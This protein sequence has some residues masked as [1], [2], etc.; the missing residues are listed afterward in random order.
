MKTKLVLY[1]LLISGVVHANVPVPDGKWTFDDPSDFAKATIGKPLQFKNPVAEVAGPTAEDKAVK[2][3]LGNWIKITQDLVPTSGGSYQNDFSIVMDIRIP[4]LEAGKWRSFFNTNSNNSNGGD[5]FIDP[6]EGSIGYAGAFDGGLY[7]SFG[8]QVDEWYRVAITFGWKNFINTFG[9]ESRVAEMKVYVDGVLVYDPSTQDITGKGVDGTYSLDTEFLLFAD[10]YSEDHDIDCA[11]V[12]YFQRVISSEEVESLGGVPGIEAHS[13]SDKY[14]AWIGEM[15]FLQTPTPTS[16]NV[17]WRSENRESSVFVEYSTTEDMTNVVSAEAVSEVIHQGNINIQDAIGGTGNAVVVYWNTAK[18]EGLSPN[19]EYFYRVRSGNRVSDTYKFKTL[20]D[21]SSKETFRFMMISDTQQQGL[22][23]D[24]I[25]EKA[26]AKIEELYGSLHQSMDFVWHSGDIIQDGHTHS[27]YHPIFFVPFRHFSSSVPVIPIFGNH[28]Y[29]SFMMYQ[30]IKNEDFSI[31]EDSSP[32]YEKAWSFRIQNTVFISLN[33]NVEWIDNHV[34]MQNEQ[35]E[36]LETNLPKFEADETVDF[37]FVST[38][39]TPMSEMWQQGVEPFVRDRILPTI[40]KYPKVQQLS[41]GHTHSYERGIY[42][43][44]SAEGNDLTLVCVAGGGGHRD[45]PGGAGLEQKDLEEIKISLGDY[46]FV[47]G[48]ID[49]TSKTYKFETYSLGSNE[50][51]LVPV[52]LVDSWIGS[53]NSVRPAIPQANVAKEESGK[54][55]FQAKNLESEIGYFTTHFQIKEKS[56][57]NYDNPLKDIQQ[58]KMN[59]YGW[60]SN[61][62]PT[63]KNAG[64]DITKL[65]LDDLT[66]GKEYDWRIR[67]RDNYR[68]W[69]D[70]S[71]GNITSLESIFSKSLLLITTDTELIIESDC[72]S[73]GQISLDVFDIKGQKIYTK[74]QQA[75]GS[76][77]LVMNHS[78]IPTGI[79]LVKI[80]MNGEEIV[81]KVQLK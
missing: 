25:L 42:P 77:I 62:D 72:L 35:I 12:E 8:F 66:P 80:T 65:E 45:V 7:S 51:P 69:S 19:T 54:F 31:F 38:H 21:Q 2:V 53:A 41:Y 9:G 55:I 14:K 74:K 49:P 29:N 56:I 47:L 67:Y 23:N 37:V 81:R 73:E 26:K 44:Q 40:A 43:A 10:P 20:A 59:V 17:S 61:F 18:I 36:W 79:Y 5:L 48:E 52:Q 33:A 28:E 71:V 75:S 32:F 46:F 4:Y 70:W 11:S 13:I 1:L 24:E 50:K 22:K 16:I 27:Q 58:D 64:L 34:D 78:N 76:S 63:D 39:Q 3:E 60:D 30:Y 57:A 15:P 6:V 68:K